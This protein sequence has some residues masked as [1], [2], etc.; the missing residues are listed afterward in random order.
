V[1]LRHKSSDARRQIIWRP[2]VA[3]TSNK[4]IQIGLAI[5]RR[6]SSTVVH[7]GRLRA[8]KILPRRRHSPRWGFGGAAQRRLKPNGGSKSAKKRASASSAPAVTAAKLAPKSTKSK[9]SDPASKQSRVIAMLQS[10]TGVTLA[11]ITKATGWQQHSV[12]GFLAGVVRKRLKL[13]LNSEKVDGSRIYRI[14]ETIPNKSA[15]RQPK[16]RSA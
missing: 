10:P 3:K 1:R 12:R 11:A 6:Q 9:K 2:R 5:I 7:K 16:Q 15:L 14:I 4:V 13:K 8:L